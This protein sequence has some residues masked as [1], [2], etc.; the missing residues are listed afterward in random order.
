[1]LYQDETIQ[2]PGDFKKEKYEIKIGQ[3]TLDFDVGEAI[4]SLTEGITKLRSSLNCVC[5]QKD[6]SKNKT[7]L[8]C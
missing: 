1:M 2:M 4:F 8:F 5:C 7:Q 3:M 6:V